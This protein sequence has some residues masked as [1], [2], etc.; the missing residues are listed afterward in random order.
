MASS[1]GGRTELR[2]LARGG[3]LNLAGFVVSGVLGFVLAIVVTRSMGARG[4]GVF[5]AAVAVFT[6]LANVTE[7]GADTG[8]VR[9]ISRLRGLG[10]HGDLRRTVVVA[11]VPSA[12]AGLAAGIATLVWAEPLADAFSRRDPGDVARFLR[13]I[14]PFLPLATVGTV[15]MAATRGFGTM[16]PFVFIENVGKPALKPVF[17]LALAIGGL[18]TA[19]VA[20]GWAIPEAL[21]CAAG[22]FMLAR[23]LSHTGHEEPT[24]GLGA[25][26]R[27]FWA[28]SA[29]RGLA[30]AFQ[31]SIVWFDLLLLGRYRTLAE[32]GVYAAASRVST[33]GTFALQAIRLAIAPQISALLARDD[34]E[35][36]QTVY[37]T[38]TWWLMAISWPFFLAL[39]VFAPFLL[40]VF[41][42]GFEEG[43]VALGILAIAMLV[44]LGTG[45]V[46][47]VLLMGG[48]SSWNLLNM[49][50]ALTLNI[51]LNVLLIPRYGIE[52]AAAAWAI[53]I[54]VDNL[55]ALTEVWLFLGMRPFGPGYLPVAGAAALSVGVPALLARAVFGVS[56]ASFVVFAVVAVPLYGA[57]LWSLRKVARLDEL[58]RAV[59]RRGPG[60]R[61]GDPGGVTGS[62][63]RRNPA[64]RAARG[65]LRGWGILT[66]DLRPPPDFMIIGTK[67]GGTT[68]LAEYLFEHPDVTPLFP[69]LTAPKGVRYFDEH[70]AKGDRWYRSHFATVL[71]RGPAR[72]PRRL[73]GES[74]ANYLFHPLAAE[75][76][77]RAAPD[78]KIVVLV[79]DPVER[80]WSHW[81][82]RSRRG[83]ETLSLREALAAEAERLGGERQR[84]LSDPSYVSVAAEN[85]AYRGQGCYAD[86]LPAWFD[87]FPRE[88]VMVIVSEELYADPAGTYRSV[89][90][91]L[92]LGDYDLERYEAWNYRPPESELP[93]DV[94]TELEEFFAPHNL[95][96][97]A[98][99]G[100]EL[101]WSHREGLQAGGA[102]R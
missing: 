80:A 56:G 21:A 46:T 18:G 67:R 76:A 36:A 41:G 5:F 13:L 47:V 15:A 32:V 31:V 55:M 43:G 59:R 69:S 71:T 44:N 4:A 17:I 68:S 50:V 74:T 37:Q 42:P 2:A 23:L 75:R 90:G 96:L 83:R 49:A 14:A 25:S 52:G 20:L 82:E 24:E 45:N 64:E 94:R 7:L 11:L 16:K 28:F 35:G 62:G 85:F 1:S 102:G 95:R 93:S 63:K 65:A 57:A 9:F 27:A 58:V 29:P 72:S 54:I 48:K 91:F 100:R 53:S 60:D 34:R 40:R 73:A 10:R 38:A 66:A 79:R 86:L 33:V 77:A 99:L 22:L 8:A 3:T 101:P 97:E 78:A 51:V 87:H 84:L 98:L 26:A 19:E 61:S 30:A 89:L 6:I 81:R 88:Q 70:H 92:G 12:L 39:A